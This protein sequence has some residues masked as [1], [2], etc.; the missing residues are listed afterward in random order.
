M[1][2][3]LDVHPALHYLLE[4]ASFNVGLLVNVLTQAQIAVNENNNSVNDV[5]TYFKLRWI[6]LAARWV[7]CMFVFFMVWENS[8][9][10]LDSVLEKVMGNSNIL[11]HIGASG[12]V[13][14]TIDN[15]FS[16][17]ASLVGIQKALPPVPPAVTK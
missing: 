7:T 10:P 4:L 15:L 6:P 2:T 1:V 13:G 8:A 9:L 5:K 17:V 12:F 14:F 16:K 11:P 3:N